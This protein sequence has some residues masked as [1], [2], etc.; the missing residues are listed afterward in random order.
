MSTLLQIVATPHQN[1][2]SQ[3]R[4]LADAF[5]DAWLTVHPFGVVETLDL[6]RLELPPLDEPMVSVLFD[7]PSTAAAHSTEWW[8]SSFRRT[9]TCS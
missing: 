7:Q 1:G 4:H 8:P 6:S 2:N 9:P 3:T 5:L